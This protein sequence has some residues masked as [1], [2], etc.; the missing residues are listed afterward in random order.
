MG[1]VHDGGFFFH[2]SRD[3]ECY[4]SCFCEPMI[5]LFGRSWAWVRGDLNAFEEAGSHYVYCTL[6]GDFEAFQQHSYSAVL[7]YA[8]LNTSMYINNSATRGDGLVVIDCE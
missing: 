1:G 6:V 8:S 7:D 4:L 3:A 5:P 2:C